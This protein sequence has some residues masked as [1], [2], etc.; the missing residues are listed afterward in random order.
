MFYVCA[1]RFNVTENWSSLY[2]CPHPRNGHWSFSFARLFSSSAEAN[3]HHLVARTRFFFVL[4][5]YVLTFLPIGFA[6]RSV[7]T[8]ISKQFGIEMYVY[9][10]LKA[11]SM[12]GRVRAHAFK[13]KINFSLVAPLTRRRSASTS[14]CLGLSYTV[15]KSLFHVFSN[16]F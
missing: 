6:L 11:N 10:F 15:F 9:I 3:P 1:V 12:G 14:L 13:G 7:Q 5:A 2:H 8:H 16:K 4:K